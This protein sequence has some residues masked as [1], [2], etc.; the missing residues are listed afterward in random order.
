MVDYTGQYAGVGIYDRRDIARQMLNANGDLHHIVVG[1]K[2]SNGTEV[3]TFLIFEDEAEWDQ[4]TS[5]Y[6][7]L[8]G[9]IDAC[10]TQN[11]IYR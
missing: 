3:P 4:W 6:Q 10:H 1:Y 7:Y 9:Y 11:P 5:L 2:D 8:G